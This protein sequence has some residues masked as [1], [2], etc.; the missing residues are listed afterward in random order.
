MESVP[1]FDN[2]SIPQDVG[3]G[4]KAFIDSGVLCHDLEHPGP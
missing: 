3:G 4:F 1:L 2:F